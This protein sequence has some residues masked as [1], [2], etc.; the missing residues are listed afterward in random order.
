MSSVGQD[1]TISN[2]NYITGNTNMYSLCIKTNKKSQSCGVKIKN[3]PQMIIEYIM[4]AVAADL[5]ACSMCNL[6]KN[7][8]KNYETIPT[9][10]P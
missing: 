9:C 5:S 8:D 1:N 6:Q 7:S 10:K 3:F 4:C 2:I